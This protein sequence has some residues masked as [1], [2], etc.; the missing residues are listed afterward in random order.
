MNLNPGSYSY[1]FDGS[2]Y[3]TGIYFYKISTSSGFT[4]RRKMVLLK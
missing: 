1:E 4:A 3:S 2:K